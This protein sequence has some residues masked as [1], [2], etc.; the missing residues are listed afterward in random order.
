MNGIE[1]LGETDV[2]FK[3][4]HRNGV[5]GCELDWAGLGYDPL[6]GCCN[7]CN[8]RPSALKRSEY[9]DQ[10]NDNQVLKQHFDP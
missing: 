6:T 4:S 2:T 7:H 1:N 5:C 3:T 9:F 10:L 8:K